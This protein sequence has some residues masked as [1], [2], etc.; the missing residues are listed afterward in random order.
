MFFFR[1]SS[2]G[3]F[4]VLLILLRL[5]FDSRSCG[6]GGTPARTQSGP[7]VVC[8][9][10]WWGEEGQH[11]LLEVRAPALREWAR[12]FSRSDGGRTMCYVQADG[13]RH[14][15][16]LQSVDDHYV[17]L[18][19]AADTCATCAGT[20]TKES[21]V[22][23]CVWQLDAH[24]TEYIA[25]FDVDSTPSRSPPSGTLFLPLDSSAACNHVH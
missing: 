7:L 13:V 17:P 11:Q 2:V 16:N 6:R 19:R 20:R 1:V 23:L 8:C 25:T 18:V 14:S 3:S 15:T 10:Q 21:L 12:D 5:Y 22:V 4:K 9:S 24:P